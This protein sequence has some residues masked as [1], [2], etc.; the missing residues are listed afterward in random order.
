M[1]VSEI[2][3]A[4]SLDQWAAIMG[5]HPAYFNGVGHTDMMQYGQQSRPLIYQID[6]QAHDNLGRSGI[7]YGI[8]EAEDAMVRELGWNL[9]PEFKT[10]TLHQP[11]LWE[12]GGPS[13]LGEGWRRTPTTLP[14]GHLI[15]GGVEKRTVMMA[16]AT[17][18]PLNEF[19]DAFNTRW[20]IALTGV[21]GITDPAEIEIYFSSAD[22]F[23]ETS[24]T[25][26]E[27]WRIR[28]VEIELDTAD[29]TL[30]VYGDYWQ[31]VKPRLQYKVNP[32]V[33]DGHDAGD[34]ANFVTTV[35][36]IQRYVDNSQAHV[37]L[38]WD[39]NTV[40]TGYMEVVSK[41]RALLYAGTYSG[42]TWSESSLH[43]VGNPRKAVVS[44]LAG[45]PTDT[46]GNVHQ[47]LA[48]VIARFSVGFM[49]KD[50]GNQTPVERQ[51]TH[52]REDMARTDR[53]LPYYASEFKNP[54]G[55]WR[56]AMEAWRYVTRQ[57]RTDELYVEYQQTN[58]GW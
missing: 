44:Y 35:D 22:R 36:V 43:R 56:G 14:D 32:G 31:L 17:V 8:K 25:P 7:A 39:D 24:A 30:T 41:Y 37:S 52:W 6:W 12:K 42:S 53:P 16:N 34:A 21:T 47:E 23:T 10:V 18:V 5:V 26:S 9:R 46:N 2:T 3:A 38:T 1:A 33:E 51:F 49:A 29:E 40:Q 58:T 4:V 20:Q 15:Q 55:T 11:R 54:F 48:T 28:P 27:R 19:G 13:V 50:L 57:N 45:E